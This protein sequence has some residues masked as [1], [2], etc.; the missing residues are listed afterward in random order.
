MAESGKAEKNHVLVV[1]DDHAIRKVLGIL[2]KKMG[3]RAEC[4][5]NGYK[6]QESY[7]K[8][9][10]E[11]ETYNVVILDLF[12]KEG[13]NGDQIMRM[14]KQI[15]P[16]VRGIICSGDKYNPI[17]TNFADFGFKS[18]LTKPFTPEDINQSLLK[19]LH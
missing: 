9:I 2:L 12:L 1:D 16:K 13:P 8:A 10:H 14:L 19:A 3:H 11:N 4:V 6:A 5:E 15:D 7:T 17:L 18:A